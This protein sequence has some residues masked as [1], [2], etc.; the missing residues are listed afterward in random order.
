MK[1]YLLPVLFLLSV[2]IAFTQTYKGSA[3]SSFTG[4]DGSIQMPFNR[5]VLSAGKV[6][7]YGNPELEN[8]ALDICILPDLQSLAI[9]DRYGI[10]ILDAASQELKYRWA[11]GDQREYKSFMNT[12][13]GIKAFV[14]QDTTYL[15]WSATGNKDKGYILIAQWDGTALKNVSTLQLLKISPA[16]N[17]IPN[18][19]AIHEEVEAAGSILRP[20]GSHAC[21]FGSSSRRAALRAHRENAQRDS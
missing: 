8:H 14:Y 11:F 19:I 3:D 5:S 7:T 21:R 6:I 1:K 17:S 13:S 9:E 10:A 18:E 4:K 15:A 12:Y 16:A 20:P 2:Q